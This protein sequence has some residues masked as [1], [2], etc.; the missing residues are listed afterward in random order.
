MYMRVSLLLQVFYHTYNIFSICFLP[1]LIF[2]YAI[3]LQGTTLRRYLQKVAA[4]HG[5]NYKV[6]EYGMAEDPGSYEDEATLYVT[7]LRE[8]VSRSIS[9]FKCKYS[10]RCTFS[11]PRLTSSHLMNSLHLFS[12]GVGTILLLSTYR[13][14]EGRWNC[15]D[16]MY[17]DKFVPSEVNALKLETWNKSHGHQAASCPNYPE[18]R[19]STCAVNCNLQWFSGSCPHWDIP[20]HPGGPDRM[21]MYKEVPPEEQYN[22][23]SAKLRRYNLIVITEMLKDPRYVAAVEDYFGV[24]GVNDRSIHPWCEDEAH[25]YNHQIPLVIHNETLRKLTEL[26]TMDSKLYHEFS[27]CLKYEGINNF[28]I[29]DDNRF[30]ANESLRIHHTVWNVPNSELQ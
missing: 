25:Y 21:P 17:N 9:H 12:G 16:M 7:H 15:T 23:A 18:F 10:E 24:P 5:L 22:I 19:M 29:W 14:D 27:D 28:P 20:E 4:H 26:N 13:S 3:I 6:F 30:H 8:P 2:I 11:P 1:Q